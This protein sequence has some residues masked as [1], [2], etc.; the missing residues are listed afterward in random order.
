MGVDWVSS[1]FQS[2][3]FV[4]LHHVDIYSIDQQHNESNYN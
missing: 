3:L 4:P 1:Q 2:L